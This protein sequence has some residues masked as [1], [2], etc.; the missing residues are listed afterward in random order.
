MAS[1][2]MLSGPQA[3]W[4]QPEL[5]GRELFR[6][7]AV[8]GGRWRQGGSRSL[9]RRSV[10]GLQ[11]QSLL[12]FANA[13]WV[14]LVAARRGPASFGGALGSSCSPPALPCSWVRGPRPVSGILQVEPRE[15]PEHALS[16]ARGSSTQLSPRHSQRELKGR[17]TARTPI[18]CK[19]STRRHLP[20]E[21]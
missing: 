2:W 21:T 1:V 9:N 6:E 19:L 13:S 10:A 18:P 15:A 16:T 11:G 4:P 12:R 3:P 20:R 8:R 17:A 5:P 14:K 7:G